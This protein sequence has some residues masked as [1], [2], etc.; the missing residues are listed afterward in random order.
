MPRNKKTDGI[1]SHSTSLS[2]INA[3]IKNVF[4]FLDFSKPKVRDIRKKYK[5]YED[6]EKEKGELSIDKRKELEKE[7]QEILKRKNLY[8]VAYK[9]I[10]PAHPKLFFLTFSKSNSQARWHAS[11]YFKKANI[12]D[13][14]ERT[15]CQIASEARSYREPE[16]DKYASK[17]KV[18]IPE[19]MKKLDVSFPCSACGKRTFSYEDYCH[20]LCFIYEGE[21]D[22]MPFANGYILCYECH[23]KFIK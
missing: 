17:G 6:I 4:N 15:V 11:K 8:G 21:Y 16:L 3:K 10:F 14:L 23:K 19:L 22:A 5:G 1:S 9:V 12:P 13:F 18:P 2:S 7:Y 20:N